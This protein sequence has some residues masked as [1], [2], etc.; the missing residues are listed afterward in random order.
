M[1][2]L[3]PLPGGR[4]RY[5]VMGAAESPP[6][7]LLESG[8]SNLGFPLW[9]F[10]WDDPW[11]NRDAPPLRSACVSHSILG[12]TLPSAEELL[13]RAVGLWPSIDAGATVDRIAKAVAPFGEIVHVASLLP[14]SLPRLRLTLR[15][16]A[17][18]LTGLLAAVD[19]PGDTASV[20]EALELFATPAT[21]IGVQLEVDDRVLPYLGLESREFRS[22]AT[23]QRHGPKLE[24]ALARLAPLPERLLQSLLTWPQRTDEGVCHSYAKLTL[25]GREWSSKVYLGVTKPRVAQRMRAAHPQLWTFSLAP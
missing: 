13:E 21:K 10:E 4:V 20:R 23:V 7:D 14:R 2:E 19:W 1:T 18:E 3:R 9:W 8:W 11:E 17:A 22:R 6:G 12:G 24:R 16:Q 15:V 25:D 5:D